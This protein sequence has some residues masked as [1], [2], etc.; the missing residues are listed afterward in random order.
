VYTDAGKTAEGYKITNS[1]TEQGTPGKTQRKNE[2]SMVLVEKSSFQS[3][4]E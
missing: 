4:S 2:K 1:E 3:Q